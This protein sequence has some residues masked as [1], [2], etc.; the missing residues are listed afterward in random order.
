MAPRNLKNVNY[1][2]S[3]EDTCQKVVDPELEK[4]PS[5]MEILWPDL[6]GLLA[7]HVISVLGL[8][9]LPSAKPATWLWGE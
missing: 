1:V 5:K 6:L 4:R 7:L 8:Y 2:T 3:E 9:L